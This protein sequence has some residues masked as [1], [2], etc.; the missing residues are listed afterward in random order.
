MARNKTYTFTMAAADADGIAESQTPAAGG[1]QSLT[2]TSSTVT[3]DVARHVSVTSAADETSRTFTVTGTDRNGITISEAITG[4]DTDE[5]K[6]TKNF[7]TVTSV[8]TDDDTAGAITVGTADELETA[9]VPA[10][11]YGGDFNIGFG[12]RRITSPDFSYD[13]E[14]TMENV[15]GLDP[16]V[17]ETT[18]S[19]FSHGTLFNE[20]SDQTGAQT[21][22]IGG[23]RMKMYNYTAG[24]LEV[25]VVEARD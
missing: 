2:L 9:W 19:S 13:L 1:V 10:N 11:R 16:T 3:L 12:C 15:L 4:L 8:T 25:D 24:S 17:S 22:P 20:T 6:G 5:A 21:V 23:W 18:F 7:L 14:V